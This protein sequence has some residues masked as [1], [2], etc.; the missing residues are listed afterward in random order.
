VGVGRGQRVQA[1]AELV[2]VSR[3]RLIGPAVRHVG[4]LDAADLMRLSSL[5]DGEFLPDDV[6]EDQA[7]LL[8]Q[9]GVVERVE[10]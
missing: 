5:E 4:V 6:T 8:R 3:Y 2:G 10:D 1:A 9:S 7:E